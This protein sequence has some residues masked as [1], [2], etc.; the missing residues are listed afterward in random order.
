MPELTVEIGSRM[1]EVACEPGQEASLERAALLLDAEAQQ[2]AN[3][4]AAATEKRMLLLSGLMLADTM[5]ALKDQLVA[6]EESLRAAEERI[7]IAEAKAAMLTANA[8]KQGHGPT[9]RYLDDT[10][11]QLQAEN[12]AAVELL[13]KVLRDLNA[14]AEDVEI[15]RV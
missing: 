11:M 2:I 7:R 4:P 8:L 13:A 12:D 3:T 5:A 1:F 10:S 14:L 6:C 9:D 15:G